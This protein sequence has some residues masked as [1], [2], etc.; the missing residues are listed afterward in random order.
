MIRAW[1][2]AQEK[3]I[4][5]KHRNPLG[6]DP[7]ADILD[8]TI[9]KNLGQRNWSAQVAWWAVSMYQVDKLS[10]SQITLLML[11]R[12]GLTLTRRTAASLRHPRREMES[13]MLC[14]LVPVNNRNIAKKT[15][16][17]DQDKWKPSPTLT[18]RLSRNTSISPTKGCQEIYFAPFPID[19]WRSWAWAL[20]FQSINVMEQKIEP[21]IREP[22]N[23][24][25]RRQQNSSVNWVKQKMTAIEESKW[26]HRHG[27]ASLDIPAIQ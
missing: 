25:G 6:S 20:N 23:I 9:R 13:W 7:A 11:P 4:A 22:L 3:K 18:T 24:N 15:R 12:G 14:K 10:Y 19:R 5:I 2:P 21:T 27:G 16:E 26:R 8:L 17:L 1:W